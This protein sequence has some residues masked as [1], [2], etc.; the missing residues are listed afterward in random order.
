LHGIAY[1]R[2]VIA[3]MTPVSVVKKM[4]Q[5]ASE[6]DE[7]GQKPQEMRPVLCEKEKTC[8]EHK[9]EQYPF[10]AMGGGV[11]LLMY[12]VHRDLLGFRLCE[13]LMVRRHHQQ[14][15]SSSGQKERLSHKASI[16]SNFMVLTS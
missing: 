1:F 7:I 6:K 12:M 11:I 10:P 8:N 13:V 15:A 5:G 14:G 4:H 16:K 9:S 3:A 2:G